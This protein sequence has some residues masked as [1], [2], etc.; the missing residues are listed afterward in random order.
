MQKK[1]SFCFLEGEPALYLR[2]NKS[3]HLLS[4]NYDELLELV[5][6][7]LTKK[8]FKTRPQWK[9]VV[10]ILSEQFKCSAGYNSNLNKKEMVN[11]DCFES[12]FTRDITSFLDKTFRRGLTPE[13]KMAKAKA[14]EKKR[15]ENVEMDFF[16][17]S[18]YKRKRRIRRRK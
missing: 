14:N 16:F 1:I 9:L 15:K 17:D 4:Y 11:P 5:K 12:R 6:A 10:N 13:E 7:E 2:E 3:Y 18:L 8:E